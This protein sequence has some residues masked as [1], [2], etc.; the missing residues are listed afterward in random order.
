MFVFVCR[1]VVKC[2]IKIKNI[3]PTPKS[4]T[5]RNPTKMSVPPIKED[6]PTAIK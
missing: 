2:N 1:N 3:K 6:I 4:M 5:H